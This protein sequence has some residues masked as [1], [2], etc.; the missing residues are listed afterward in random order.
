[1]P[2]AVQTKLLRLLDK[3]IRES[4]RLGAPM[5]KR[6][7]V[8]VVMATGVSSLMTDGSMR[9]DLMFRAH[10]DSAL[11]IPPLRERKEDI[12]ILSRH[13]LRKYEARFN[14]EPR[15]FTEEALEWLCLRP[16]PGN[17][18][19]LERTIEQAV[20][21]HRGLRV[22]SVSHLDLDAIASSPWDSPRK[23]KGAGSPRIAAVESPSQPGTLQD[24]WE[25]L[26]AVSVSEVSPSE[27]TGSLES[28]QERY[29]DLAL[30]L[31]KAA[32]VATSRSTVAHPEGEIFIHP[33][34]KLLTGDSSLTASK[35]ADRVKKMFAASPAI[36]AAMLQDPA[37]KTAY[38]TALRLRP[39]RSSRAG[40]KG[41]S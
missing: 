5:P 30:R 3:N 4:Q 17:V 22:L 16:W 26:K 10:L 9:R 19:E 14:A 20:F 37:L 28:L 31:F 6:L 35:A 33:A 23:G 12:P 15:I 34:M 38:D 8:L 41:V 29:A 25:A 27:L 2:M 36:S 21:N 1:M 13:F 32:L 24:L 40:S 11:E 39:Q 7:D 18:R